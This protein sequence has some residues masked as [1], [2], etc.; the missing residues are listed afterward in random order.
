MKRT[1]IIIGLAL[2][3]AACGGQQASPTPTVTPAPTPA[4]TATLAAT[5]SAPTQP[6]EFKLDPA[7]ACQ[8]YSGKPDPVPGLP[9]ITDADWVKGDPAAPV[10]LLEYGDYQ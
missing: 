8:A 10:V 9:P 6:S 1:F 7:T 3:L 2:M 5:S 4:P